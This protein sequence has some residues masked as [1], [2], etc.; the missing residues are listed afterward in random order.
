MTTDSD[1]FPSDDD[2]HG[3]NGPTQHATHP[4]KHVTLGTCRDD[5]GNIIRS[6]D[7]PLRSSD[8]NRERRPLRPAQYRP[9]QKEG[10]GKPP[11]PAHPA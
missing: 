6:A 7:K 2:E 1:D 9:E 5:E 8:L 11:H 4:D 10:T 3:V